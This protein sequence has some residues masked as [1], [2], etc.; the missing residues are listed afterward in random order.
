MFHASVTLGKSISNLTTV[1]LSYNVASDEDLSN[2]YR[3]EKEAQEAVK[4]EEAAIKKAEEVNISIGLQA[5]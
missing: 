2:C 4:V 1:V 3:A 5:Y